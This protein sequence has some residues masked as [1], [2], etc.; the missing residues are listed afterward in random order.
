MSNILSKKILFYF[1]GPLVRLQVEAYLDDHPEFLESYVARKVKRST[2]DRWLHSQ[3]SHQVIVNVDQDQ[4]E[5][6]MEDL[7]T[8]SREGSL[9][10]EGYYARQVRAYHSADCTPVTSVSAT[11]ARRKSAAVTPGRKYSAANFE[12]G[13]RSPLLSTAEDGSVS[14]LTIPPSHFGKSRDV[15]SPGNSYE[16]DQAGAGLSN[17]PPL[18]DNLT[19]DMNQASLCFKVAKNLSIFAKA[20]STTIIQVKRIGAKVYLNINIV[21]VKPQS[22]E[23]EE[24][25]EEG[26]NLSLEP[27]LYAYLVD[28]VCRGSPVTMGQSE[29]E[30]RFGPLAFL[31]PSYLSLALIPLLDVDR[32][33]QGL[34]MICLGENSVKNILDNKLV[35]DISKL[36]GIC[37][38]N[39]S[40]YQ[41]M[42]L[43]L[44]RSQV[45]LELARAIFDNQMSIEF[46][47]LKVRVLR[48]RCHQSIILTFP[49]VGQLPGSD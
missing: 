5:P 3:D 20:E 45:F 31:A 48:C 4:L 2:V 42:R 10:K 9:R 11:P 26:T 25:E 30:A 19:S 6:D 33:V 24:E 47:V 38:K 8:L 15:Q 7:Q 44:T 21:N 28:L 27:A 49:D 36:S 46:T 13:C 22:L 12:S 14:F 29:V 37:M 41:S 35:I 17:I 43:E 34:A 1:K 18:H 23:E 40:E 16:P 32:K 39:A